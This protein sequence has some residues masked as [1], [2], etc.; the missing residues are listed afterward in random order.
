MVTYHLPG[1]AVVKDFACQFR[2]HKRHGFDPLIGKIPWSRKWQPT[3]L[4][5]L[6]KFHRQKS[7]MGYNPLGCKESDMA[8]HACTI[9]T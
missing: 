5:L 8:E 2:R 3:P 4:I 6:G 1:G 9:L 7:L